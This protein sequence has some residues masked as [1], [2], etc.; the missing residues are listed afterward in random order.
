MVVFL[1]RMN[2]RKK[3][4]IEKNGKKIWICDYKNCRQPAKVK[5]GYVVCEKHIGQRIKDEQSEGMLKLRRRQA[6][7]RWLKNPKIEITK[8]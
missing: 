1:G 6:L 7:N 4:F 3:W 2:K 8:P 5:E